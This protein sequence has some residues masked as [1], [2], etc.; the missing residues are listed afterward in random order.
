MPLSA[1][2]ATFGASVL[3]MMFCLAVVGGVGVGIVYLIRH[4]N[5][6]RPAPPVLEAVCPYP[7]WRE[8]P[9][10]GQI[11]WAEVPFTDGTGSKR[12]PTLVL[13]TGPGWVQVFKITSQDRSNRRDH[14]PIPTRG[15]DRRATQDS[16]LDLGQV[17]TLYDAAFGNLAGDC[18]PGTWQ[19][20][21]GQQ[22]TGWQRA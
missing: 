14:M 8:R 9:A 21:R 16:W 11:W 19:Y 5:R 20:V 17:F 10:P 13:R 4:L 2:V 6:T 22:P 7:Q 3:Q 18:D 1:S 12:R 15:W